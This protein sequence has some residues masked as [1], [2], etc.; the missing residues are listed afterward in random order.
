MIEIRRSDE[1]GFADHGW[2]R[3]RHTFSFAGYH[4][5]RFMGFRNLRVINEDQVAGGE[6]FPTHG[7][8][9]MEILSYV[10]EGALEH[11]DSMGNGS[12]I[13]PGDVQVMSAG[14]G[15]MHSEYN[16]EADAD[17]KFLQIWI[18]PK[19]QGARPGYQQK[20][21]PAEERSGR[22]RLVASPDGAEGSLTLH[23]DARV[24]TALLEPGQGAK[25]AL[26]SG[27]H[28]WVQVVRGAVKVENETLHA[29]DGCALRDVAEIGVVG[30]ESAEVLAFDLG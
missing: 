2:L 3:T 5:P 16:H 8:R 15:V 12:V 24:Y 9:D 10:L 28:G 11:K 25:V 18:L 1:R 29:G 14:T 23:A 26:E 19:D 20:A 6:G 30:V 4:D 13:R 22:F 17:T 27:R 7:H 21:F